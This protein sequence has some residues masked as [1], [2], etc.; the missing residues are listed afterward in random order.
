MEAV[1]VVSRRGPKTPP[2]ASQVR[3]LETFSRVTYKLTPHDGPFLPE[4][5]G[6]YGINCRE[7]ASICDSWIVPGSTL[8]RIRPGRHRRGGEEARETLAGSLQKPGRPPCYGVEGGVFLQK[9]FSKIRNP[10]RKR[11]S[12]R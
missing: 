10:S 5:Y 7:D 11:G 2:G 3:C 1:E 8:P 9:C 4:M 12:S 6:L